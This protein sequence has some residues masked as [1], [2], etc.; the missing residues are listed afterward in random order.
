[1]NIGNWRAFTSICKQDPY[2]FVSKARYMPFWIYVPACKLANFQTQQSNPSE[3]V[4]T[5][6]CEDRMNI[7]DCRALTSVVS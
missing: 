1:M 3:G 6:F 7:D 4:Q 5:N 2:V